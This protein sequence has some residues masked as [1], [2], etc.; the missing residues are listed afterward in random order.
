[1]ETSNTYASR[2]F[3]RWAS[4][5]RDIEFSG[6]LLIEPSGGRRERGLRAAFSPAT[7]STA[8]APN[9]WRRRPVCGATSF[10][11]PCNLRHSCPQQRILATAYDRYKNVALADMEANS[12]DWL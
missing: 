5:N 8:D 10:A 9:L 12:P 1:P 2:V 3:L 4:T 11:P 7:M 6:P